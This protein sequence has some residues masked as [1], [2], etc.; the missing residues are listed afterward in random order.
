MNEKV[1]ILTSFN[2]SG[3]EK[4]INEFIEPKTI[5]PKSIS[6]ISIGKRMFGGREQVA[7]YI[8]MVMYKERGE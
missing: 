3:L 2:T 5:I 1:K 8:V 7:E 6:P 4:E